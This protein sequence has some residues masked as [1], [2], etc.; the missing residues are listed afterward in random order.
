M[1]RGIQKVI[2]PTSPKFGF[3]IW[4]GLVVLRIF[5][6][7]IVQTYF[8]PDEY[9]QTIE[10]SHHRAFGYGWRTWEWS[11]GLRSCFSLIP[12]ITFLKFI[13]WLELNDED[14]FVVLY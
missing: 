3:R 13:R 10:V 5:N 4:I 8:D 9:W 12:F 2:I 7:M 6:A 14:V 11:I 1:P